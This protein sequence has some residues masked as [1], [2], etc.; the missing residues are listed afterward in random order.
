M[1][2]VILF[3]YDFTGFEPRARHDVTGGGE[4]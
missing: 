4:H 3:L 2:D 1:W